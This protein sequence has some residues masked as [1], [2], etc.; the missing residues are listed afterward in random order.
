MQRLSELAISPTFINKIDKVVPQRMIAVS[1]TSIP[2]V[3]LHSINPSCFWFC[4]LEEHQ[5]LKALEVEM[6]TFYE[7]QGKQLKI[8]GCHLQP[9]LHVAVKSQNKWH[10]AKIVKLEKSIRA[11][12]FFIDSG[13]ADDVSIDEHVRYLRNDFAQLPATAHRGI[14]SYVK[15]KDDAWNKD[16]IR[17]MEKRCG[18][19]FQAKIHQADENG[20]IYFQ[21]IK[22]DGEQQQF[23][24]SLIQQGSCFLDTS[25]PEQ[26]ELTNIEDFIY[27]EDGLH[28]DSVDDDDWL[29][30]TPEPCSNKNARPQI[31]GL[32]KIAKKAPKSDTTPVTLQS[33]PAKTQKPTPKTM[34]PET[35]QSPPKA[36]QQRKFV[37]PEKRT[38]L[39][40]PPKVSLTSRLKP[41]KVPQIKEFGPMFSSWNEPSSA[42]N[43]TPTSPPLNAQQHKDS[44]PVPSTTSSCNEPSS[45]MKA[46]QVPTSQPVNA[47]E[48]KYSGPAPSTT[49]SWN[50]RAAPR[51]RA[52]PTSPPLKAAPALTTPERK[53]PLKSSVI[54]NRLQ[55][56]T[57]LQVSQPALMAS[58]STAPIPTKPSVQVFEQPSAAPPEKKKESTC[59]SRQQSDVC[60]RKLG[61]QDLT[62]LEIGS[63]AEIVVNVVSDRMDFYFFFKEDLLRHVEFLDRFK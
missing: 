57:T 39:E 58:T 53:E 33:P 46:A 16:S 27:Y 34:K 8:S 15:P 3:L 42:T 49:S 29:P 10:R 12:V 31:R 13:V 20:Q 30:K 24:D 45:C 32:Q 52:A 59:E 51:M 54:N 22:K 47:Q 2:I 5:Q 19:Q 60:T 1:S 23:L 62:K 55:Q 14:L 43:A 41:L 38:R 9:W 7:E 56:R 11:R 36:T 44:R 25:F 17:F 61:V 28:L 50:E 18:Q 37:M 6:A 26:N 4:E 48:Q 35:V 21:S 40:M 63:K